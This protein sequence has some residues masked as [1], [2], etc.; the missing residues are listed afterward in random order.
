MHILNILRCKLLNLAQIIIIIENVQSMRYGMS[1][2]LFSHYYY[3]QTVAF[4]HK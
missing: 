1:R 3:K 4:I 2:L